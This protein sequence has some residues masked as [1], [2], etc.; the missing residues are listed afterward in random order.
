MDKKIM[1]EIKF[2]HRKVKSWAM[3]FLFEV[4]E[5]DGVDLIEIIR[6]VSAGFKKTKR[7]SLLKY[8]YS[9]SRSM[10]RETWRVYLEES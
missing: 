1:L 9:L 3:P 6:I 8:D 2:T 4:H 10:F 7:L 5:W